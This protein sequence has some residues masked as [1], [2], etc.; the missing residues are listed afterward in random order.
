MSVDRNAAVGLA[1]T[2]DLQRRAYRTLNEDGVVDLSLGL[3]LSFT[4]LCIG[5]WR[6][7]GVNMAAWSGLIPI[8]I[9]LLARRLRKRFV[10]P[11]IGY[12]RARNASPAILMMAALGLLLVAGLVV[13]TVYAR[14]GVRPP[15][16][17]IPWTLR[18]F[19]LAVAGTLFVMGR[20]TGLVRFYLHAAVILV[21]AL[22]SAGVRDPNCGLLL[23]L[24]LPGLVLTVA[25]LV[26]FRTFLR[27]HPGPTTEQARARS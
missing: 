1:S 17:L 4:A 6:L 11:R 25:G 7:G 21:A 10:Y 8:T 5:L 19:A 9:M 20:R 3:G 13:M 16:G 14:R 2:A 26:S 12:A 24:G 22:A 27:R 18:L 15:A 23:M